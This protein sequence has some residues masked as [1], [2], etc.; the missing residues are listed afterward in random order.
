[1]GFPMFYDFRKLVP[2]LGP[3][4]HWWVHPI[5]RDLT[6]LSVFHTLC[7]PLFTMDCVANV[8]DSE[9]VD[10]Q[11][12]DLGRKC[13]SCVAGFSEGQQVVIKLQTLLDI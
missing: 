12:K 8:D 11:V 2:P 1:M 13:G 7:N 6:N 3:H 10:D 9:C 4:L 5:T